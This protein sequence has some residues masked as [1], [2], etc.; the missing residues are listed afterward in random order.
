MSRVLTLQHRAAHNK[1]LKEP[2]FNSFQL[3]MPLYPNQ[4]ALLLRM[5]LLILIGLSQRSHIG[6]WDLPVA[7]LIQQAL[8]EREDSSEKSIFSSPY[9]EREK[10]ECFVMLETRVQVLSHED[11]QAKHQAQYLRDGADRLDQNTAFI[12]KVLLYS[13]LS[14]WQSNPVLA[15]KPT[16]YDSLMLSESQSK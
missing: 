1:E 4:T 12:G 9:R 7:S 11:R 5:L 6:F 10:S 14:G 16:Q 15:R 13:P 8:L 2:D 3:F